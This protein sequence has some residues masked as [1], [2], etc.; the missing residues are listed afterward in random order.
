MKTASIIMCSYNGEKYLD[1]SLGSVLAQTYPIVE[2]IFVDDG[3]TDATYEKACSFI[4]SFEERGYTMRVLRQDNQG[5]GYA[6]INGLKCATGE[7]LSFLDSDDAL[8]PESVEKRVNAL[9]Y[10]PQ[11]NIVRT[12]GWRVWESTGERALITQA[13]EK[14][15]FSIY[16]ALVEGIAHNFAGTFM[17]RAAAVKNYYGANDIPYSDYGQNLQLIL[18]GAWQSDCVFID[19]PLME[20]YIYD[21][22][23]SHKKSLDEAIRMYEGYYN[24]RKQLVE[25]KDENNQKL[26][27]R[28]RL[29]IVK[30]ILNAI[31]NRKGGHEAFDRYY[32]ELE[33]LKGMTS[34]YR[35]IKAT[36]EGNSLMAAFHRMLFLVNRRAGVEID[37]DVVLQAIRFGIVGV[38]ATC[39][40]YAIYWVLQ[41][42]VNASVAY[43]VGYALSFMCN[44]WLTSVFTFRSHATVKKGIG[45][46]VAHL[47]N[48]FMQIVLL[49]LFLWLGL[50]N[51][52]APLPVFCIVIPV[53]F[54]LVRFVF[55]K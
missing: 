28:A 31:V 20:Y 29:F 1:R 52:W 10:N 47:T 33:E 11:C 23:H 2:L 39:L 21:Q 34:E 35:M 48:Y 27:R 45:F 30:Q 9:D 7:Y 13:A 46:G 12:D 53:N 22:T 4:P 42:S 24:L 19:E 41:H 6:A 55:K 37:P 17:V 50:S 18:A 49:N 54:I 36:R 5:P 40:H 43:T 8:L 26:L 14:K 51:E 3:S 16:D 44:F 15:P 25:L 32:N 38:F